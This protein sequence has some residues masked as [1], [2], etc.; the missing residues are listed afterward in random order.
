MNIYEI[1][2]HLI[3]LVVGV[4]EEQL[5]AAIRGEKDAKDEAAEHKGAMESRYDTFKEEAQYLAGGHA[6]RR[7]EI[8]RWLG[9]LQAF[10]DDS[11]CF[12]LTDKVR[13]GVIVTL[14]TYETG[15]CVSYFIVPAGGGYT[16]EVDKEKFTTLNTASPLSRSLILKGEGDETSIITESVERKVIITK[17]R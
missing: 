17:I 3:K 15:E 12:R 5:E 9:E 11:R 7:T 2:Q 16:F 1:K 8:E 14:K 10:R 6:L 13:M 4:L